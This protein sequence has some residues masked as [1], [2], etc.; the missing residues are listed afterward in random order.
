MANA[1]SGVCS[2]WKGSVVVDE[3]RGNRAGGGAGAEE[4]KRN[5]DREL[6]F[7]EGARERVNSRTDRDK[8]EN[9]IVT[10]GPAEDLDLAPC[11]PLTW[12]THQQS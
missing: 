12:R 2:A 4:G 11:T 10:R 1:Q 7:G 5:V 3:V 8:G 9:T 6:I